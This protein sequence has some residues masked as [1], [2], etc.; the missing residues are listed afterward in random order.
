[1]ENRLITTVFQPI[2]SL[3]D[4]SVFGY[5]ALS[6]GPENTDL[7]SPA[8][9]FDRAKRYNMLWELEWLCRVTAIETVLKIRLQSRIFLNVNP[10]IM[11]DAK[12]R[13]GF[14]RECLS[15]YKLDPERIIFEIT[16]KGVVSDFQDFIKTVENYKGRISR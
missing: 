8:A 1:M 12:F 9:I 7:R 10:K 6:R 13:Q 5:E 14:T 11:N 4:G 16:E 2:V 3:R 15:Q